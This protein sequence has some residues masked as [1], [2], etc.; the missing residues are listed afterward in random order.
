MESYHLVVLAS[1]NQEV[2][3]L[4]LGTYLPL[5][6]LNTEFLRNSLLILILKNICWVSI[7]FN[8]YYF[9]IYTAFTLML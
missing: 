5:N 1:H 8:V 4:L 7:S 3:K 2:L 6:K 9:T